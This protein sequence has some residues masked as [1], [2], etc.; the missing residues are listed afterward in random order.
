[1]N[2]CY[3][4]GNGNMQLSRRSRCVDCEYESNLF[5][6]KENEKLRE[7]APA[8][9]IFIPANK[10]AKDREEC[11]T[12]EMLVDIIS[13]QAKTLVKLR[14]A[15]RAVVDSGS[16]CMDMQVVSIRKFKALAALLEV[17]S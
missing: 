4:C 1:M 9:T 3:K 10:R 6:E 12:Q 15:A 2:D 7:Y 11:P 16:M 8:P 14:E 5:N 13:T 17:E